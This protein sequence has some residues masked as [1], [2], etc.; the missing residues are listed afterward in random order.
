MV[1]FEYIVYLIV[2]GSVSWVTNWWSARHSLPFN[3]T[4]DAP[5]HYRGTAFSRE[6]C[7]ILFLCCEKVKI[8]GECHE[9]NLLRMLAAARIRWSESSQTVGL[10]FGLILTSK[11]FVA[12]RL[13]VCLT[14]VHGN[15][16]SQWFFPNRLV[17]HE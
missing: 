1:A 17:A 10:S 7:I 2:R 8:R 12:L 5:Q 6:R 13:C 3:H 11:V 4:L 16:D 9:V 15:M 14:S